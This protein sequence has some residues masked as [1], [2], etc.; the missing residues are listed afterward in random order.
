MKRY[1]HDKQLT[2]AF[3]LSR[4]DTVPSLVPTQERLLDAA[5]A[6]VAVGG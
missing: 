3:S 1:G 2:R 5:A 6:R 4:R